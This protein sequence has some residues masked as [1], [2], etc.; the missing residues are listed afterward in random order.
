MPCALAV[1]AVQYSNCFAV[2]TKTGPPDHAPMRIPAGVVEWASPT[3]RRKLKQEARRSLANISPTQLVRVWTGTSIQIDPTPCNLGAA[4]PIQKECNN[5]I[6]QA[7]G[8]DW[9]PFGRHD[10]VRDKRAG[11]GLGCCDRSSSCSNRRAGGRLSPMG[12]ARIELVR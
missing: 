12:V 9:A 7:I 5:A 1:L 3:S 11:S 8:T 4:Y 10:L 6:A 2:P